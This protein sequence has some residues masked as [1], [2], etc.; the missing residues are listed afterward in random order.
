MSQCRF[1]IQ[2]WRHD[3]KVFACKSVHCKESY[4]EF[5][6][7]PRGKYPPLVGVVLHARS[8]K[9]TLYHRNFWI[10]FKIKSYRCLKRSKMEFMLAIAVDSMWCVGSPGKI[11]S[12]Y[13]N[14][15]ERA[16]QTFWNKHSGSKRP[17]KNSTSQNYY[18]DLLQVK[19]WALNSKNQVRTVQS[20][21]G[22]ISE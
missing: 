6:I 2:W 12:N 4:T 7:L 21:S 20:K 11:M 14:Q 3:P 17:N 19:I 8:H 1:L 13:W 5:R 22:N 15:P 9:L 18:I 10:L 16:T